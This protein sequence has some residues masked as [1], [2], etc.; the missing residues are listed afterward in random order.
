M[1]EGGCAAGS[2]ASGKRPAVLVHTSELPRIG[3]VL[4]GRLVVSLRRAKVSWP[5]PPNKRLELPIAL[6]PA[7]RINAA[8]GH[9]ACPPFGGHRALA[10]QAWC[11]AD[12][13]E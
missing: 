5:A 9:S 2:E 11:W 6:A 7:P 12:A 8:E 4:S 1:G 13:G 3:S 10:A